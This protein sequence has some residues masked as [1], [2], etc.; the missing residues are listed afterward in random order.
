MKTKKRGNATRMKAIVAE[1][2]KIRKV[3]PSKKWTTCIKEGSKKV[4]K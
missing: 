3:S 1:A 2:R 4:K